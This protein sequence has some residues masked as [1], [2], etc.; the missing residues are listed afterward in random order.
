MSKCRKNIKIEKILLYRLSSPV[1]KN[2]ICPLFYHSGSHINR[3]YRSCFQTLRKG[4]SAQLLLL[5]EH[6]TQ[7]FMVEV[8]T[9][10][11]SCVPRN[12]EYN[13]V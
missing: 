9:K 7:S 6:H 8:A 1:L 3:M 11:S 5:G 10:T 12:L 13:P 2:D 4:R